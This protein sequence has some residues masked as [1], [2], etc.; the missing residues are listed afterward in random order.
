MSSRAITRHRRAVRFL[1]LTG[2]AAAALVAL[3]TSAGGD[4]EPDALQ[5][6]VRPLGL[7][8]GSTP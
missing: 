5:P 2:L 6:L 1:G 3:S 7:P 4:V 8:G